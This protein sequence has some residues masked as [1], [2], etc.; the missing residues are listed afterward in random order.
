MR[1]TPHQTQISKKILI[2]N[3]EFVFLEDRTYILLMR[4][5]FP[6]FNWSFRFA[7][8]ALLRTAFF[9]SLMTLSHPLVLSVF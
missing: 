1:F 4:D 3:N 7:F 9:L 6:L 8:Q 5:Y 2:K